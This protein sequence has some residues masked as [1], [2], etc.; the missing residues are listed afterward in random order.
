MSF[1]S[2]GEALSRNKYTNNDSEKGSVKSI[3]KN[4]SQQYLFKHKI[5]ESTNKTI[6]D[7]YS[8]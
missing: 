2:P 8:N 7:N 6:Y 5:K 4:Q 1:F 3:K